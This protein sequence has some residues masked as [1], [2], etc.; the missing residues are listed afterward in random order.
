[1]RET[2]PIHADRQA[3][4]V[5]PFTVCTKIS[6][7]GYPSLSVKKVPMLAQTIW[8]ALV[9]RILGTISSR[10]GLPPQT[11]AHGGVA[12]TWKHIWM[13]CDGTIGCIASAKDE[14]DIKGC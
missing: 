13:G 2:N 12:P 1:M 7:P 3:C 14:G 8:Q 5:V 11:A 10:L 6:K 9:S 4:F